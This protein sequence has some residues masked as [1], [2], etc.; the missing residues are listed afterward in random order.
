LAGFLFVWWALENIGWLSLG[1]EF[2]ILST[3]FYFYF[4]RRTAKGVMPEKGSSLK[5]R[6]LE[7]KLEEC[8]D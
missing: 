2:I 8:C 5:V 1:I 6:E 7:E 3:V 4:L